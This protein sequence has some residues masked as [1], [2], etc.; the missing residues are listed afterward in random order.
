LDFKILPTD[1]YALGL[2][3]NFAIFSGVLGVVLG[4]GMRSL[5]NNF[6]SGLILLF[7]Q[8]LK[9]GDFIEMAG[10]GWGKVTAIHMR[11]TQITTFDKE[12]ILI[13]NAELINAPIINEFT[14]LPIVKNA[15]TKLGII[16]CD[17][18]TFIANGELLLFAHIIF[19]SLRAMLTLWWLHTLLKHN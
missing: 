1:L 2:P 4:F 9:V 14:A 19:F 8:P 7:E 16:G 17:I 12:D 13:P 11:S 5:V 15:S 3:A 6:V 10:G 18:A